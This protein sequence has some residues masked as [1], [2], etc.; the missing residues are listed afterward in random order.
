MFLHYFLNKINDALHNATN[1]VC[2][3]SE[4][5]RVVPRVIS[6][7]GSVD[8]KG[9]ICVMYSQPTTDFDLNTLSLR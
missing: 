4:I 9:V 1:Y 6:E 3:W 2:S 8:E 7:W 5:G